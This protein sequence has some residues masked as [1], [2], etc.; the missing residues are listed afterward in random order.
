MKTMD[1]ETRVGI[2]WISAAFAVAAALL[3]A[4]SPIGSGSH[5]TTGPRN[6]SVPSTTL[7]VTNVAAS[8]L[9]AICTT[10][11]VLAPLSQKPTSLSRNQI[12]TLQNQYPT[13]FGGVLVAP[14]RPGQS[15]VEDDLH[16]VVLETRRDPSLQAEATA[17]YGPPFTVSFRLSTRSSACLE[18]IQVSL[19]GEE[20][21]LKQAG[22]TMVANGVDYPYYHVY[23]TA[24]KPSTER[25]AIEWFDQRWGEAV[26]VSTCSNISQFGGPR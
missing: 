11:P 23:V 20:S 12:W 10:T 22:I 2:M 8:D 19:E 18:D 24:C 6:A 16:Y 13:I 14:E 3:C 26:K 25:G 5:L 7:A 4:C 9:P 15:A 1:I 17:A 21:Q